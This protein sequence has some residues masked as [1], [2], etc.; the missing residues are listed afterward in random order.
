MC[1]SLAA[2]IRTYRIVVAN[3]TSKANPANG[4]AHSD[5]IRFDQS[6]SRWLV[7]IVIGFVCVWLAAATFTYNVPFLSTSVNPGQGNMPTVGESSCLSAR[8]AA[9]SLASAVVSS[10]TLRWTGDNFA[11]RLP[12]QRVAVRCCRLPSCCLPDSLSVAQPT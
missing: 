7:L 3:R 5:R 2:G 12:V 11:S 6:R 8:Q 10:A 1:Y 4:T 9:L